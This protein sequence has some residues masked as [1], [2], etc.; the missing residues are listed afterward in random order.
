MLRDLRQLKKKSRIVSKIF[1]DFECEMELDVGREK[2][3][4]LRECFGETRIGP[5]VI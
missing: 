5:Q 1:I 2:R 4:S 3:I